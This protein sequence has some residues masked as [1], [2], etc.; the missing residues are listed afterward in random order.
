[1]CMHQY[2]P[3]I[4]GNQFGQTLQCLKLC[5]NL[6]RLVS[7]NMNA[8]IKMKPSINVYS[9]IELIINFSWIGPMV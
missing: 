4:S 9:S 8:L 5:R 1:M 6:Q 2:P 7:I 3:K